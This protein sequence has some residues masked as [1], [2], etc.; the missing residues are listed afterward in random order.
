MVVQIDA[1]QIRDW[2]T[3]HTV[4]S[5]AFGFPS[6]YGRNMD[7]W[8]DCM[9]YLDDPA[10][11]MSDVH[12]PRGTVLT[13]QLDHVDEFIA[14]CPQQYRA[15]IECSAFVNWRRLEQGDPSVLALSFYKASDGG[16]QAG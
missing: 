2:E 13:I 15:L 9:T 4:F 7:A 5:A 10:A 11:E 14:H 8:I 3:F 1:T 6:F 16:P 12:V